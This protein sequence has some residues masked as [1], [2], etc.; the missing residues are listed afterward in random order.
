MLAAI[1]GA[2]GTESDPDLQPEIAHVLLM[3]VV[4]YSKLL[5]DD[6]IALLQRLNGIVRNTCRFRS[7]E[8]DS[9]L[10]RVP[11][12]DGMALLFFDNPEAPVH[13]AMEIAKEVQ[14]DGNIQLRMGAHSGPIRVI[15]DVNDRT[16]VA[17]AGIDVAQR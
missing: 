15:L 1:R 4:G 3:D 8:A 2:M 10:M 11:T 7:A 13:C 5:V 6:Q 17:G 14:A 16:N 12:G 9:K